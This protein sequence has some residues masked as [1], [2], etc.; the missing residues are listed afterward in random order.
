M[1]ALLRDKL[2]IG[3]ATHYAMH[4]E[5]TKTFN[6]LA[7]IGADG[8]RDEAYWDHVESPTGVLNIPKHVAVWHELA[9]QSRMQPLLLLSYTH[10]A[11]QNGARPTTAAGR[12]GFVRYAAYAARALPGVQ[13]FQI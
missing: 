12:A 10:P 6:T 2:Q 13:Q 3:I 5:S 1:P 9:W 4:G 7:A 8:L 11:Y